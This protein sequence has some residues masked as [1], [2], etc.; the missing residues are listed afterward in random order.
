MNPPKLW[1]ARLS[2]DLYVVLAPLARHA[3]LV[4]YSGETGV[5]A[6]VDETAASPTRP[7][8]GPTSR[9]RRA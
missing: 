5:F 8:P 2:S 3:G 1:H 6:D 7:P 9:S 4:P